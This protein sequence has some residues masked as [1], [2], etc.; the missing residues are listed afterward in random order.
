MHILEFYDKGSYDLYDAYSEGF[1]KPK[2]DDSIGGK[3]DLF[4]KTYS[5]N[6]SVA[7]V[8]YARLLNTNDPKDYIISLVLYFLY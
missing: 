1:S 7:V 2:R 6:D 8:S 4:N 3:D 5:Y